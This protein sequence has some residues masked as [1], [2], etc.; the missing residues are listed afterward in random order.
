[1]HVA[2]GCY[3]HHWIGFFV[4]FV[5]QFSFYFLSIFGLLEDFGYYKSAAMTIFEHVF[6]WL[7]PHISLRYIPGIKLLSQRKYTSS[8]SVYTTRQISKVTIDTLICRGATWHT[9]VDIINCKL[10]S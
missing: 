5:P 10:F 2:I 1:M 8:A 6:W 7:Y 9:C 3:S 4:N